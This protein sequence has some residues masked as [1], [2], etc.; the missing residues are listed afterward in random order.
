MQPFD[1]PSSRN[2]IGFIIF[3][4][5]LL[6]L[7]ATWLVLR[8]AGPF[9]NETQ[10][11]TSGTPTPDPIY[12]FTVPPQPTEDTLFLGLP[13]PKVG[14][15]APDFVLPDSYG[16][17]IILSDL[18]GSIVV[19]N[20]W[21]SWCEPC[22]DE[23]PVL[24]ALSDKYSN[25]GLVV[26]GVNTTYTDS[27]QEALKFIDELNLTFPIVFDETGEGGEKMY[28]VYGLPTSYWINREG[29][30]RWSQLGAMTEDQMLEILSPLL[31][32]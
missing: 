21:A 9:S 16:N 27:Y 30:I 26:L 7:L 31:K 18:V 29:I 17:P 13:T 3:A 1:R 14:S 32:P 19:L 12:F 28:K 11:P 10:T 5:T 22:R 24:Q 20:F 25:E 8:P 15:S 6:G 23:M 4:G 2:P